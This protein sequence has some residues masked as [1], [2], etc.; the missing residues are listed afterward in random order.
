M[1]LLDGNAVAGVLREAFGSEMTAV[2]ATCAACG[3]T[4]Q[5]GETVVYPRLPGT[6]IRCRYCTSLLMV[7]T[8]VRGVYCVDIR[9]IA[10][11]FT[12]T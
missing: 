5:I 8:Q 4:A 10:R 2:F 11:L 1:E 9:G 3:A 7:V 12:D 6:V